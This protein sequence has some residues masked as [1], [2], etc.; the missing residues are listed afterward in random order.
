MTHL[1]RGIRLRKIVKLTHTQATTCIYGG[2]TM[3]DQNGIIRAELVQ[4]ILTNIRTK[5][6]YHVFNHHYTNGINLEQDTHLIRDII[7]MPSYHIER[8]E[9]LFRGEEL[10]P[11][12]LYDGITWT[13]DIFKPGYRN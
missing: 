12:L 10:T 7:S 9:I 5:R 8:R 2:I 11:K 13:G 4:I 6:K 1:A 3:I